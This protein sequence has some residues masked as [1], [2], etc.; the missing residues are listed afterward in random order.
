MHMQHPKY[1]TPEDYFMNKGTDGRKLSEFHLMECPGDCCKAT[2]QSCCHIH[3]AQSLIVAARKTRVIP[4]G[5]NL[6]PIA[7]L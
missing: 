6:Y 7:T 2:I 1:P 3:Q 4:L 5:N